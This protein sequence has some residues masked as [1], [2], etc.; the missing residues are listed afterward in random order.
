MPR[1]ALSQAPSTCEHSR[2]HLISPA[3]RSIVKSRKLEHRPKNRCADSELASTFPDPLVLPDDELAG[4]PNYPA[5]SFQDWVDEGDRN[6]MTAQRNIIYVASPP[7]APSSLHLPHSPSLDG[8]QVVI[9][10]PNIQDILEYVSA[11]YCGIQV[12]LLPPE[13]LEFTA[14]DSRRRKGFRNAKGASAL[15]SFV[16]L[17]TSTECVRIRN[18]Q[19]PD[20]VFQSQLNLGDIIEAVI[21]IVPDDAYALIMLTRYDLYEEETDEFQCGSA[22]GGSRVAVVSLARYNPNL[23]AGH[24]VEREHAWPASHCAAYVRS[25]MQGPEEVSRPRK[26]ARKDVSSYSLKIPA[27]ST[28]DGVSPMQEA[29]DAYTRLAPLDQTFTQSQLSGMWLA[30]VCRTTTHELG[31]CF[32]IDHCVYYACSMQGTASIAEDVRQPPYLCPIDLTKILHATR[33]NM[34][35]RYERIAGFLEK[36]DNNM[37]FAAYAAWIRARL[38]DLER[39]E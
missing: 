10:E 33:I 11:F 15:P 2:L 31:H 29:L 7:T 32:G 9:G 17:K 14:W 16:G 4:D 36:Y 20:G 27:N 39:K 24:N 1:K 5:Q 35:D 6:E 22:Y 34:E 13:A 28:S 23:D 37:V 26:K 25:M 18:R 21:S 8:S 19:S 12:E 30:R 38:G 3:Y